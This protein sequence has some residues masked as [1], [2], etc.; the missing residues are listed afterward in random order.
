MQP[1]RQDDHA[2]EAFVVPH[3]AVVV[4]VV[5]IGGVDERHRGEA[6]EQRFEGH[7]ERQLGEVGAEA[8][9]SARSERQLLR[10]FAIEVQ[11]VRVS[12]TFRIAA[13]GHQVGAGHLTGAKRDVLAHE[14]GRRE[15]GDA[16]R[17]WCESEQLENGGR[18]PIAVCSELR[19]LVVSQQVV[20]TRGDGLCR[21]LQPA[22]DEVHRQ[23]PG[24][25]VGEHVGDAVGG[26]A[27]SDVVGRV[28]ALLG[29]QVIDI[30]TELDR[31]PL[32]SL[33]PL[34]AH[35][36]EERSHQIEG[37]HGRLVGVVLGNADDMTSDPCRQRHGERRR[38]I[39]GVDS[40]EPIAQ[41]RRD[42]LHVAAELLDHLR[43]EIT[44][45][46]GSDA[47]MLR[48]VLGE[49]QFRP[50]VVQRAVVHAGERQRGHADS[51]EAR[52]VEHRVD[53]GL[54]HEVDHEAQLV[55]DHVGTHGEHPLAPLEWRYIGREGRFAEWEHV[56]LAHRPHLIA[57][58]H[59]A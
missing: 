30:R 50:Q 21:C 53:V 49:H 58:E 8:V 41:R 35:E 43:G 25:F 45:H 24:L 15:P 48:R 54:R 16:L 6:V 10:R 47:V 56:W 52:I 18:N 32:R 44:C 4:V 11:R 55:G 42:R 7:T 13:C 37:P 31:R 20:D 17:G 27:R 38:Q 14:V 40:F 39:R 1:N 34:D 57:R 28:S 22:E 12:M 9:V 59:R 3:H 36:R 26:K 19:G 33:P 29:Q 23:R 5:V 51:G 2:G 46:D